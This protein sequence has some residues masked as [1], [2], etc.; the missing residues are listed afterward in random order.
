MDGTIFEDLPCLQVISELSSIPCLSASD[1]D[2]N[3][4]SKVNFDYYSSLLL[5]NF[6]IPVIFK[7]LICLNHFQF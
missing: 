7:I 1:P 4:P 6:I 2:S 3:M 5:L